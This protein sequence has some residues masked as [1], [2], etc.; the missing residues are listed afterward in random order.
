[1]NGMLLGDDRRCLLFEM[2]DERW[3]VKE[4]AMR[5]ES[6]A[7]TCKYIRQIIKCRVSTELV[8]N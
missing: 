5:R 6:C 1:M 8:L 3:E 4:W 7:C 2:R